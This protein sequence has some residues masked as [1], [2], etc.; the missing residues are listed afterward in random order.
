MARSQ[1]LSDMI[2]WGIRPTNKAIFWRIYYDRYVWIISIFPN[3]KGKIRFFPF[4][5]IGPT[6]KDTFWK[7]LCKLITS[8]GTGQHIQNCVEFLGNVLW[9]EWSLTDFF[10]IWSCVSSFNITLQ[11]SL[12]VWTVEVEGSFVHAVTA[13]GSVK[14][15]PAV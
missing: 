14:F 2:K 4:Y 3:K 9:I 12:R 15:L 5:L 10:W 7:T 11:V 6:N 1:D 13:F 8:T